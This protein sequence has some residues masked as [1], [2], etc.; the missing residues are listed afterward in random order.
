M[1]KI[2]NGLRYD[3]ETAI[4]IGSDSYSH[5][6]DFN[7]WEETLY[8]TPRAGRFF[9]VGEG[10]PMTKYSKSIGQNQWTGGENLTPMT[11]DEA[12]RWCEEHLGS[13]DWE[14]Y[15]VDQIEEA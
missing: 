6:G 3:S 1:K 7:F 8:K 9:L 14:E 15:F 4:A 5:P 10:G 2:I 11:K 13:G 12:M